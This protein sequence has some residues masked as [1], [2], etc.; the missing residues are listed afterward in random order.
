MFVSRYQKLPIVKAL[1]L[2]HIIF[3][4]LCSRNNLT[5][6]KKITQTLIFCAV[7]YIPTSYV[8]YHTDTAGY[9]VRYGNNLVPSSGASMG[10]E[11]VVPAV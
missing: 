10:M 5:K 1:L 3:T 4:C 6:R 8:V 9:R 11:P 7:L 2:K